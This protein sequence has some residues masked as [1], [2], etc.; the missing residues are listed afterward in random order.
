MKT[1]LLVL[2]LSLACVS[3]NNTN[4]PAPASGVVAIRLTNNASLLGAS[5]S[6]CLRDTPLRTPAD[7]TAL[8]ST[9]MMTT[10]TVTMGPLAKGK[11]LYLSVQYDDVNRPGYLWPAQGEYIQADLLVNGKMVNSVLLNA[12]SFNTPANYMMADATRMNLVQ[13][14]AVTF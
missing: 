14:V 2:A 11:R 8:W 6:A 13:E 10:T 1:N 7:G 12:E 9:R 3:C 5:A 4:D